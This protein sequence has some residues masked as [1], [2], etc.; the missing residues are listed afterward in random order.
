[1]SN[2]HDFFQKSDSEL[3]NEIEAAFQFLQGNMRGAENS[4]GKILL[5]IS[6]RN[7][8]LMERLDKQ[9]KFYTL[10]IIILTIVSIA[11]QLLPLFINCHF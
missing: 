1:M 4:I 8:R 3:Q 9:N 7:R 5:V 10:L 2:N 6:E 11:A